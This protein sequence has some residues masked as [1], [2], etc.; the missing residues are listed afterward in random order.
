MKDL[1]Q[2]GTNVGGWHWVE[3][4]AKE[5]SRA[6]LAELLSGLPLSAPD[7]AYDVKGTG[8]TSLEGDCVV[9]SRKGKLIATY[10]LALRLGFEGRPRDGAGE[11]VT[12]DLVL[13][14][15]SEENHDEDPELRVTTAAEGPAA[16]KVREAVL[17]GGKAAALA[18]IARYVA[19]LRAGG[20]IR[21]GAAADGAAAP[22]SAAA[23]AAAPTA[24]AAPKPKPASAKA[25][26]GGG[27][28][29]LELKEEF[30]CGARDVYEC[31]TDPRKM[32]AFTQSKAEAEPR[33]GGAFSMFNGTIQGVYRELEAPGRLVMDWRFSSWEEGRFSQVC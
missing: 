9:N 3:K 27:G 28:Q 6:R 8:V 18:A 24:A 19:E 31:F 14:Y 33:P 10:E 23:A 7:S 20:P 26:A 11:A 13:P 4:D 16:A 21:P 2:Q 22:A 25:A 1:G 5:W 32:S 30:Y 12:G 15:V 17:A 29:R